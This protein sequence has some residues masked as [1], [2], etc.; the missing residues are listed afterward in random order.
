MGP[1]QDIVWHNS[2]NIKEV[3]IDT[4]LAPTYMRGTRTVFNRGKY[5]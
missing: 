5:L 4:I 2:S 1:N 3:F